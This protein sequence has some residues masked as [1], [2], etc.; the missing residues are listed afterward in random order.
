MRKIYRIKTGKYITTTKSG[1]DSVEIEVIDC[2][3]TDGA[4]ANCVDAEE[5]A[6]VL[7]EIAGKGGNPKKGRP[8]KQIK[9]KVGGVTRYKCGFCPKDFSRSETCRL[10]ER[11]HTGER[12]NKC[13]VCGKTFRQNC[14]L[15]THMRVPT[16]EKPYHCNL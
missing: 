6:S 3:A 4:D 9:I 15:V 16:A 7:A 11:T 5:E 1:A 13:T 12:P 10:H 2:S 8:L 14:H